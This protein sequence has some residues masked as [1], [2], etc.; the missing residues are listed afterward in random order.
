VKSFKAIKKGTPVSFGVADVS[1][2]AQKA[3]GIYGQ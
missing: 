3:K 1:E 2:A